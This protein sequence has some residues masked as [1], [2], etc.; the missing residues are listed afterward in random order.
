MRIL[1]VDTASRV[2]LHT[3]IIDQI[4]AR[5]REG[6]VNPW[7]PLP[8][9][10]QLASD[11]Q[12]SPKTVA[13]AYT[14]L[15]REGMVCEEDNART[16][17]VNL[18]QE[19]SVLRDGGDI[20]RRAAETVSSALYTARVGFFL[21]RPSDGE[22]VLAWETDRGQSCRLPASR[23]GGPEA[24]G[25]A[26]ELAR[27]MKLL[28]DGR[29]CVDVG[30]R[31]GPH[32]G[33]GPGSRRTYELVIALRSSTG[34]RGCMALGPRLSG[35]SFSGGE[36]ELLVA[37]ATQIGLALENAE[38]REVAK[39]EAE[40]AREIEMAREVQQ[41]LLPRYLPQRK[42][43]E[44]AA[45]SRPA[46]AVGGD[47]YDL[48]EVDPDHIALALGDVCGKGLGPS[49]IMSSVH[50]MVRNRLRH[51]GVGLAALMRELND[52]LFSS[53]SPEMYVTLLL[54]VLDW[55]TGRLRYV[56][57]G[58]NPAIVVPAGDRAPVRLGEGGMVLGG[59]AGVPYHEGDFTL[60]PG[61]LLTLFS[62]GVTEAMDER[63]EMFG[64]A[65][66]FE[67]IVSSRVG[68]ASSALTRILESV[69][70]FAGL[71]EQT[72]DISLVLLKREAG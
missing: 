69:G 46:R 25:G 52:H 10:Q 29:P 72:D 24:R 43:W 23:R 17:L 39:R 44:V 22:F 5:V 36:K 28:E 4:R 57:G 34:L 30:P 49:M 51:R 48:I 40:H 37:V 60:E 68:S 33:T 18:G 3:Q 54:G 63:G 21:R 50:A 1:A 53:T 35:Q 9:V 7:A 15:Q 26:Q 6:L 47:Y 56:N 38:L 66:L 31:G 27:E 64:E 58:H 11:L 2:P 41:N 16:T 13:K 32:R 71:R 19:V 65:R 8:S 62:D 20:L 55:R 12:I 59:M 45:V 70:R 14:L 42:G 67:A 61:S